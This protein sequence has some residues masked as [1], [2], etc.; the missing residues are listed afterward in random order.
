[1]RFELA[2]HLLRASERPGLA[3]VAGCTPSRWIAE[4]LPSVHDSAAGGSASWEV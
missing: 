4:E 1:M 2:H 3:E